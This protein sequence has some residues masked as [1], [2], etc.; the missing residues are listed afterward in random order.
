[1]QDGK[2]VK[3]KSDSED[4][5]QVK[6]D[7]EVVLILKD[8]I[9]MLGYTL[10]EKNCD[11]VA[12][13]KQ[14]YEFAKNN[15]KTDSKKDKEEDEEDKEKT[16]S[17]PEL[18]SDNKT[19]ESEKKDSKEPELDYKLDSVFTDISSPTEEE[20]DTYNEKMDSI[21]N[22]YFNFSDDPTFVIIG[23]EEET[24]KGVSNSKKGGKK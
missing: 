19:P 17:V 24:T 12:S 14:I 18:P 22:D 20:L 23:V 8:S 4:T 16:D 2:C 1:M 15:P 13:L 10:S 5:K 11:S 7:P 6:D 21:T 3:I 9:Q